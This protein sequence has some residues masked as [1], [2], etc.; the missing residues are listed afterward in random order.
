VATY[1][2][3]DFA[4]YPTDWTERIK[5][6][7]VSWSVSGGD[8]SLGSPGASD[9]IYLSWNDVDGDSNRADFDILI[10]YQSAS[11]SQRNYIIVGRGA[12]TD[13]SATNYSV[14]LA[15]NSLRTHV[16][17]ATDTPTQISTATVTFATGSN[18]WIRFRVNGSAVKA[19]IWS[20]LASDEPGGVASD[21]NWDCSG[22]DSTVSAAGWIGIA[23]Y[24]NTVSQGTVRQIGIGTGGDWGPSS[25][26]G[27]Y[28]HP[29]LSA[30]TATEITATSFKPRVTYTF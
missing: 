11:V 5:T 1:F 10:Q 8:L 18:Y 2:T 15:S 17:N 28:T 7:G 19:K 20:G 4:D 23:S 29:T 21:S 26:G 24:S 9:W 6:P 30:V 27:G 3:D 22:T 16:C 12:G 14:S 25:A 13:E